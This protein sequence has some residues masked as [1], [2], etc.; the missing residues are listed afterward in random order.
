MSGLSTGVHVGRTPGAAAQPIR[1]Q[2]GWNSRS[3]AGWK[4]LQHALQ[5]APVCTVL[6]SLPVLLSAAL[7]PA[8]PA[9]SLNSQQLAEVLPA[10][11]SCEEFSAEELESVKSLSFLQGHV[12]QALAGGAKPYLEE[13]QRAASSSPTHNAKGAGQRLRDHSY[14][15]NRLLWN[16]GIRS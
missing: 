12:D 3:L 10:D 6:T 8:L 13:H 1:V 5:W 4:G 15:G 16:K 9:C 11:A 14:V 2:A 7:S